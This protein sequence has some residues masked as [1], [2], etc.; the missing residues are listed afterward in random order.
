MYEPGSFRAVMRLT[1]FLIF[2]VVSSLSE[3][4]GRE[5]F[6]VPSGVS[7]GANTGTSLPDAWNG[8]DAIDWTAMGP[9]DT[10]YLVGSFDGKSL[11]VGSGGDELNDFFIRG[12]HPSGRGVINNGSVL[13]VA[14]NRNFITVDGLTI[15][16][17][18]VAYGWPIGSSYV[19]SNIR[20]AGPGRLLDFGKQLI[21]RGFRAGMMIRLTGG[22]ETNRA[23]YRIVS[24]TDEGGY[25]QI[26]ID[27]S[28]EASFAFTDERGSKTIEAF[29]EN[30]HIT[31]RNCAISN[32]YG[33]LVEVSGTDVTISDNDL[34]AMDGHSAGILYLANRSFWRQHR[35]ITISGNYIH[36]ISSPDLS[37]DAHCV[38]VQGVD[39]LVIT[40]N[41]FKACGAA[42]V[43]WNSETGPD[44][45]AWEITDN[46]I[47]QMDYNRQPA[48][49]GGS[50]IVFS[51]SG[52]SLGGLIARNLV[53]N[54]LNCPGDP[55]NTVA[56]RGIRYNRPALAEIHNN[57]IDG[58]DWGIELK[59]AYS[60]DVRNNVVIDS[61]LGHVKADISPTSHTSDYNAYHPADGAVFT[62]GSAGLDFPGYMAAQQAAGNST[63][64][65]SITADPGLDARYAPGSQNSAVVGAGD[66]VGKETF[67]S[68][69]WPDAAG[70]G[71]FMLVA[72]TASPDIG[73][74][75]WMPA[76]TSAADLS[77]GSLVVKKSITRRNT[78][79][80][81]NEIR[82]TGAATAGAFTA[83]WYLS[84]NTTWD[85]GLDI[86][87]QASSGSGGV[88]QKAFGELAPGASV[89]A[90]LGC[91]A[92][93]G[94]TV[95]QSY[96]VIGVVDGDGV[97][98]E[99]S[100]TNNTAVSQV[101][102]TQ[103][104][105]RTTRQ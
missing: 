33:P 4:A 74:F 1:F 18:I 46:F 89:L 73:A 61:V 60:A 79:T 14:E 90:V 11:R 47:E 24:V 62:L 97:V 3:A 102:T 88:C 104:Q 13:W 38:G 39:G 45:G 57:T 65:H 44:I 48:Q 53:V 96:Y 83:R 42:I 16:N 41:H 91:R 99:M 20:L 86:A 54:P 25:E 63:D 22:L 26:T 15:N 30:H 9:G 94:A 21:S 105:P 75:A 36:N 77:H 71:D 34:D 10:L 51:D 56:C 35:N 64:P 69:D 59:S 31:V 49:W 55:A 50:G 81:S 72:D 12:D 58:Y 100:E 87:L 101:F 92:P 19:A 68:A 43:V 84:A 17:G 78:F 6:V 66:P 23:T 52:A 37:T 76:D 67:L 2:A 93:T 80:L 85:P 5:W 82:N 103:S 98:A 95:G 27:T 29:W 32:A 7:A 8:F 28:P 70:G 40:K